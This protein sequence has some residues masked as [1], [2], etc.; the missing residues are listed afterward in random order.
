MFHIFQLT[1]NPIVDMVRD[2]VNDSRSKGHV[3]TKILLTGG[4]GDS[5]FLRNEMADMIDN[6]NED[7]SPQLVLKTPA[8][9]SSATAVAIGANMRSSDKSHGP[10][11]RPDQSIGV[12]RHI[13]CGTPLFK[14]L[15]KEVREQT[16]TPHP[17]TGEL[18][19]MDTIEWVILKVCYNPSTL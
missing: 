10:A 2:F 17:V 19:I 12:L 15:R 6:L 5:R 8:R 1:T 3:A 9:G 4:F 18:C 16:P 14:R 7:L 11:R 13:A